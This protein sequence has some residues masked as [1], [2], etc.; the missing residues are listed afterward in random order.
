MRVRITKRLKGSIDGI[1]LSRLIEGRVYDVQTS[2]A[3]YLLLEQM[4]EP[5]SNGELKA[6]LPAR[7]DAVQRPVETRRA[8]AV[9]RS[10]AADRRRRDK[11]GKQK[12]QQ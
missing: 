9:P 10:I 8:I 6:V 1:Q 12:E 3:C 4:A 11:R 5:A 2:L 7:K